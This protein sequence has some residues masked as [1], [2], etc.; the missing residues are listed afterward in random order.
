MTTTRTQPTTEQHVAWLEQ[1]L[2][3][4][5][6]LVHTRHCWYLKSWTSK[7]TPYGP[8]M[9]WFIVDSDPSLLGLLERLETK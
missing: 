3:V 9:T 1:V 6:S 5:M 7:I 2:P 8:K 4:G